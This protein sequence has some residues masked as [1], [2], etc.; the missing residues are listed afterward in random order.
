MTAIKAIRKVCQRITRRIPV[1][2][3]TKADGEVIL[4]V[5]QVDHA[6]GVLWEGAWVELFGANEKRRYQVIK[7]TQFDSNP[8][9][10]EVTLDLT[11]TESP[12]YADKLET[13]VKQ[14]ALLL[15]FQF[16]HFVELQQTLVEQSRDTDFKKKM[17]PKLI[18]FL[19]IEEDHQSKVTVELNLAFI[20]NTNK[21]WKA[22]DRELRSFEMVLEP[23]YRLFMRELEYAPFIEMEFPPSHKKTDR[24]F[25]GSDPGQ[26]NN[27]AAVLDAI[28]VNTLT[29]MIDEK[30]C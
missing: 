15:D 12:G 30:L 1:I 16:G 5:S 24:Y 18:L 20:T 3:Y 6:Q 22:L 27:L 19:D 7:L 10:W 9:R 21:A 29:L 13:G 4:T 23:M 14:M 17:Y 2:E 26:Q 11:P 8:R 28:E 25:W